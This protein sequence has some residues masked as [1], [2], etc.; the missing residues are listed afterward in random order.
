MLENI[1]KKIGDLKNIVD[2]QCMPGNF[3]Q[4]EYMRGLANGLILA[5]SIILGIEP[6]YI[7]AGE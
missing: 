6:K 4:G 2:T 1:E 5:Q 7:D 3:D